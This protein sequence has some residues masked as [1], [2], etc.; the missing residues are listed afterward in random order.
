MTATLQRMVCDPRTGEVH[1]PH[2]PLSI[3]RAMENLGR[4]LIKPNGRRT[5]NQ[6]SF[7]MTS[8]RMTMGEPMAETISQFKMTNP[9]NDDAPRAFAHTGYH[10]AHPRQCPARSA[11]RTVIYS[12]SHGEERHRLGSRSRELSLILA[13]GRITEVECSWPLAPPSHRPAFPWAIHSFQ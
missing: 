8:I 12:R 13:A 4:T 7:P 3:I 11:G 2:E 9:A 1:M 6:F 10:L 5:A